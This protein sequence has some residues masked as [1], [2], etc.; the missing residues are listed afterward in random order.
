MFAGHLYHEGPLMALANAYEDLTGH[1][2]KQP[3][4]FAVSG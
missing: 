1:H 4:L 2:L 3:P